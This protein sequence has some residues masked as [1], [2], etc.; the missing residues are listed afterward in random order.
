MRERRAQE[1]SNNLATKVIQKQANR[2]YAED[3]ALARYEY[4][5]EAR[6][7]LEDERRQ[8][9]EAQEKQKMRDLLHRQMTEKRDREA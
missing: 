5:R 8:Q 1:F 3:E 4:E 9:R 6:M 7:R 2:K